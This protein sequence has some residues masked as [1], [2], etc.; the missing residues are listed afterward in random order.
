MSC[1]A[2][3]RAA[4]SLA[5][6]SQATVSVYA[7]LGH[8]SSTSTWG[9]SGRLDAGASVAGACVP[10]ATFA[11]T[12]SPAALCWTADGLT[13]LLTDCDGGVSAWERGRSGQ[14]AAP[15]SAPPASS[16]ACS[17]RARVD[18]PQ[19][20][21]RS[22]CFSHSYECHS[23]SIEQ[24]LVAAGETG[25]SL[26][27]TAAAS[28]RSVL[29]WQAHAGAAATGVALRLPSQPLQLSWRTSGVSV[30]P[31]RLQSPPLL[32]TWSS[33]CTARLWSTGRPPA[34]GVLSV[35]PL[36]VVAAHTLP[37]G[38]VPLPCPW[39]SGHALV[40]TP[41]GGVWLLRVAG[42]G[43]DD[44]APLLAAASGS[45]CRG[46][47]DAVGDAVDG[48]DEWASPWAGCRPFG[49]ALRSPLL[50]CP[51][52]A[53]PPGWAGGCCEATL[54][55]APS[56]GGDGGG[57][58]PVALNAWG[59]DAAGAW[60]G[61]AALA[62]HARA[63][64]LPGGAAASA[65][66]GCVERIALPG[67]AADVTHIAALSGVALT[68]D[69]A[70]AVCAWDVDGDDAG[71][72]VCLHPHAPPLS[73]PAAAVAA[74]A[75]RHVVVATT[76]AGARRSS[77][78]LLCVGV[79]DDAG[80]A[81]AFAPPPPSFVPPCSALA[82]THDGGAAALSSDSSWVAVWTR[83]G[84]LRAAWPCSPAAMCL[85]AAPPLCDELGDAPSWSHPPFP[86]ATAH[87]RGD[88][89]V[90]ARFWALDGSELI[91]GG[92]PVLTPRG[93]AL[94]GGCALSFAPG[95]ER[96]AAASATA[97]VV[98]ECERSCGAAW[99]V[100][101]T[102]EVASP[103]AGQGG[104]L[105][106][107]S[108]AWLDAGAAP[109]VLCIAAG[110]SVRVAWRSRDGWGAAC[111]ASCALARPATA[112]SW[113]RRGALLVA[114]GSAVV[115]VGYESQLRAG[116]EGGG[117]AGGG[118]AP[119]CEALLRRVLSTAGCLPGAHP[120]VAAEG[121]RRRDGSAA[122][123]GVRAL[124]A[125]LPRD[126]D[127]HEGAP[128]ARASAQPPAAPLRE[129]LTPREAED[130]ASAL[131]HS[132][133][134]A[135]SGPQQLSLSAWLPR[136]VDDAS[137]ES[138]CSSV[139]APGRS[140]LGE[141]AC[142]AGWT[143]AGC[144][145][146]APADAAAA[147]ACTSRAAAW[148]MRCGCPSV[149]LACAT[150]PAPTPSVSWDALR[151]CAAPLW[152][153]LP[154]LRASVEAAAR[155]AFAASRSA[156]H[157]AALLYAAL[158]RP[159][160]ASG[161]YKAAGDK[162]L[163][164][165]FARDFGGDTAE[166]IG[167][168]RAASKNAYALLGLNRP[169]LAAAFFLLASDAGDAA[170]TLVSRAKEPM[171]ALAVARLW[172]G[173]GT[174]FGGPS[175]LAS[176]GPTASSLA[177]DE[178]L[179][180]CDDMTRAALLAALGRGGEARTALLSLVDP[181]REQPPS[182]ADASAAAEMLAFDAAPAEAQA[183]AA[184]CAACACLREGFAA[185]AAAWAERSTASR[186]AMA[187]LYARALAAADLVDPP[188]SAQ[189]SG[190]DRAA[191]A[192]SL[193]RRTS[194]LL[195]DAPRSPQ[196]GG[197]DSGRARRGAAAGLVTPPPHAPPRG[198]SLPAAPP[199]VPPRGPTPP[200]KPPF[201]GASP[202]M[203]ALAAARDAAAHAAALYAAAHPLMSR[204]ASAP[205]L[206]VGLGVAHRLLAPPTELFRSSQGEAVC[207]A[208]LGTRGR[209]LLCL[210]ARGEA[211]LAWLSLRGGDN[212]ASVVEEEEEDSGRDES[213]R[214]SRWPPPPTSHAPLSGCRVCA[215]WPDG[216]DGVGGLFAV[217]C[218]AG[219]APA[220]APCPV[221]LLRGPSAPPASRLLCPSPPT[222]L[223]WH[224]G[225]RLG[226]CSSDG[227]LH[228]WPADA[229]RPLPSASLC[230]FPA[231]TA[232][233]FGWV[234]P[235]LC[236]GGG[237]G[238]TQAA[239]LWD[240]LQ[241]RGPALV[242]PF[243]PHAGGCGAL[244]L[245]GASHPWRL[246]LGGAA[247]GELQCFDL[248]SAERPL[249]RAGAPAAAGC[250]ALALSPPAWGACLEDTPA[251]DGALLFA[252]D[253]A[254]DVKAYAARDGRPIAGGVERMHA[255]R[256]SGG[257]GHAKAAGCTQLIVSPAVG[258]ISAGIDGVVRL[259]SL[260]SAQS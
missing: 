185:D 214:L 181:A 218:V 116:G 223:A 59:M 233:A 137:A 206:C 259:H 248:R 213:S 149:L 178:L 115:S 108:L 89:A 158:R 66:A 73:A 186:G 46:G 188:A 71:G 197:G 100:E 240:L 164:S 69:T 148:A 260:S 254:G 168:R 144:G 86:L 255:P 3:A 64:H 241:P 236:C 35:A 76:A 123:A 127:A 72:G 74:V 70:G 31:S 33:D 222:R 165:F 139:D 187:A 190:D 221:F 68:R 203:G 199:G 27:A 130:A 20:R 210:G 128:R 90:V 196:P 61:S 6:A 25:G 200:P 16:W 244:S 29:V 138:A 243:P 87:A 26:F 121:V 251:S 111:E 88:G 136:L 78:Q 95:G 54:V 170:R 156:P 160:I 60:H 10:A 135:L 21:R 175:P 99:G 19:V 37:P 152:L 120:R 161:L 102:L 42:V 151:R 62:P 246:F 204:S 5:A 13:L 212:G 110:A 169:H 124:L 229:A 40:S 192:A 183:R 52:G 216:D 39:Q 162:Q 77:P 80:P 231:G 174:G 51:P 205:A 7:P 43:S 258:L 85:C 157:E 225:C 56:P 106:T 2:W 150:R 11:L 79:G 147:Q 81:R 153:P 53:L 96:L 134:G 166:G 238:S 219:G 257:F 207:D 94:P 193:L 92:V 226:G 34:D 57:S 55:V 242:V 65:S 36:F 105:P 18:S 9:S 155:V 22:A 44:P 228:V 227:W 184:A 209:I 101:A 245:G 15:K 234:S 220:S 8:A 93:A 32:L 167:A 48:C 1:L 104:R 230:A 119:P 195:L 75:P 159:Q 140:A 114:E 67:H 172:D 253:R 146:G 109:P 45:S 132:R 24:R 38:H 122:V 232:T 256:G 145:E 250:A 133:V 235:T 117:P 208:A 198:A 113:T 177:V 103:G 224:P 141:L 129:W 179:P 163:A 191:A 98:W 215:A 82:R 118:A 237:V 41:D 201:G 63:P 83:E 143:A 131:C 17:W 84:L 58:S 30:L 23:L 252:G 247:A 176:L 50:A 107:P 217:G 211:G 249:W 194:S 125:S 112:V 180:S 154:Q 171:L 182:A 12:A 126:G 49:A 97:C 28:S 189:G 239:M 91:A 4:S 14:G 142:A 202:L 173:E 47:D